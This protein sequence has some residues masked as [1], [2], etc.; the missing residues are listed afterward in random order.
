MSSNTAG[1]RGGGVFL[2]TGKLTLSNVTV[3]GNTAA[4]NGGG[5]DTNGGSAALTNVS[6]TGNTAPYGGGLA[7]YG[8]AVTVT[9]GTVSGNTATYGGGVDL[10]DGTSTLTNVTIAGNSGTEGGALFTFQALS[11]T[12]TNTIVARQVKGG[13]IS[14]PTGGSNYYGGSF[15][16][17]N[18]TISGNSATTG[19]GL[20]IRPSFTETLSN[21]I[22]AGHS[23]KA[24]PVASA[25][26]G[27]TT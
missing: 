19:G 25:S 5:L 6:I 24:T 12:L 26:P 22:V 9:N 7:N 18:V 20:Y 13:D 10:A 2:F 21:T 3:S 27:A 23:R 4:L 1:V 11:K 14:G 8:G 17:T 16:L 15:A